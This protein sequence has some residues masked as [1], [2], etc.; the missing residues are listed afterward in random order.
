[1]QSLVPDTGRYIL[2]CAVE[3]KH[4]GLK[5]ANVK[6]LKIK[7]ENMET[8]MYHIPDLDEPAEVAEDRAAEAVQSP[9]AA[10]TSPQVEQMSVTKNQERNPAQ[11]THTA[12]ASE[13]PSH[14][15]NSMSTQPRSDMVSTQ[16]HQSPEK[17]AP[18]SC[19]DAGASDHRRVETHTP[20]GKPL[21]CTALVRD[22]E[23]TRQVAMRYM[24][25]G[26]VSRQLLDTPSKV[27]DTMRA[28]LLEKQAVGA[29]AMMQEVHTSLH[30]DTL[31]KGVHENCHKCAIDLFT[32]P[33]APTLSLWLQG[34]IE[35]VL[36]STAGGGSHVRISR[37]GYFGSQL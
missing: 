18:L 27:P 34:D 29:E 14:R 31:P 12:A 3:P 2:R 9:A 13:Q 25:V 23:E 11:R 22:D 1:M 4:L 10:T 28:I 19:R 15:N 8:I 17:Q 6:D 37:A 20:G 7:A 24:D 21:R 30:Q 33:V 26:M 32:T 16:E 36:T 35:P 5:Q